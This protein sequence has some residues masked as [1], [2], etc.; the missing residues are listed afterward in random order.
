MPCEL[1]VVPDIIQLTLVWLL[2]RRLAT[3]STGWKIKSSKTPELALPRKRAV[4]DS[5][6]PVAMG[7]DMT[8]SGERKRGRS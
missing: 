8:S 6:F 2:I 7:G 3:V 4:P 1:L 5:D